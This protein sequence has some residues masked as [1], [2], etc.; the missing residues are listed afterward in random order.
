ASPPLRANE[1]RARQQQ[2]FPSYLPS[3]VGSDLLD[4]PDLIGRPMLRSLNV[5][6][7]EPTVDHHVV[8]TTELSIWKR[9]TAA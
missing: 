9:P 4:S 5:G 6:L 7:I 2:P 1:S 8:E 3:T